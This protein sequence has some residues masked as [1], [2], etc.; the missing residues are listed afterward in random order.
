M[1][2]EI[3][4][5]DFIIC[6]ICNKKGLNLGN[7][8]ILTHKIKVQEYLIKFPGSIIMAQVLKDSIKNKMKGVT[9][10]ERIGKE[11]ADVISKTISD[12]HK[13]GKRDEAYKKAGKK[14]KGR[15]WE[16]RLD[17]NTN[18]QK[19]REQYSDNYSG[20]IEVRF[21]EEKAKEL[22]TLFHNQRMGHGTSDVT[23]EKIS[24]QL[25]LR[26]PHSQERKDK[27]RETLVQGHIDGRLQATGGVVKGRRTYYQHPLQ[28]KILLKSSTEYSY[29]KLLEYLSE[30]F[31]N[32][33]WFYEAQRFSFIG[34]KGHTTVIIPDFILLFDCH[35]F[36]VSKETVWSKEAILDT[37]TTSKNKKIVEIKGYWN[38]KHIAYKKWQ[39]FRQAFPNES[40]M[41]FT[42]KQLIK[43][44]KELELPVYKMGKIYEH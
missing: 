1:K 17:P 4:N 33:I 35:V 25:K 7:H 26:P 15:S 14:L 32:F 21:G 19:L 44:E 9:I 5:I 29:V 27:I 22:H 20:P 18:A 28:G 13:D 23:K 38:E 36:N 11:R 39:L 6:K 24:T 16:S 3:E 2:E 10:A 34:E 42:C 43:V 30:G 37:I 31:K 8:I 41:I 12:S 40:A